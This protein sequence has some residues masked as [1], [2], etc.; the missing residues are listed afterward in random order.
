MDTT[1]PGLWTEILLPRVLAVGT[2]QKFCMSLSVI[3]RVHVYDY[4]HCSL[5]SS[6]IEVWLKMRVLNNEG[7][8]VDHALINLSDG[9]L[10]ARVYTLGTVLVDSYCSL[11]LDS[12]V[13]R[14][15]LSGGWSAR[16]AC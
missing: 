15:A 7:H 9:Y 11:G 14:P 12:L 1:K 6:L 8:N 5:C 16:L 2:G 10:I 4:V 13:P 3:A